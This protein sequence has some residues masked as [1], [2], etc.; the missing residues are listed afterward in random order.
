MEDVVN[1]TDLIAANRDFA[2]QVMEESGENLRQCYQCGK[3]S[4]GCPVAA[5]MDIRPNRIIRMVLL[6]MKDEVLSSRTIWMCATCSTCTTRCPRDVDLAKIMDTLRII[7]QREGVLAGSKAE[8]IFHNLFLDSIS[9]FGRVYE[10]G[11]V[12][13]L[14]LKTRNLFKDADL[15]W[16]MISKGKLNLLPHRIKGAKEVAR[17]I[18]EAKRTEGHS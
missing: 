10:L 16:P 7:A 1:I 12:I 3:C 17:I 11:L 15:G 2:R 13:G 8:A 5:D 14:N 9:R 4:A 18:A 6:G